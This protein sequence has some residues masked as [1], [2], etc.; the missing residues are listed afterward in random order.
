M[1]A[2]DLLLVIAPEFDNIDTSGAL[3]IA[4]IQVGVNLCGDTR[5]LLVAYLAA[6]ILTIAQRASG[7][8]GDITSITEGHASITYSSGSA[9]I[10]TG[11]SRTNY[12]QEFDRLSKGCIFTP[13]TRSRFTSV[14]C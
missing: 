12:G 8:G 14:C 10:T 5:P 7:S 2:A 11:L 3:A 4:E 13:R 9:K 1:S 6:H